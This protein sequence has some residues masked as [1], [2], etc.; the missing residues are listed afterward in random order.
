MLKRV[1]K[2]TI[3]KLFLGLVIL[4]ATSLSFFVSSI[5][6]KSTT[7]LNADEPV[8]QTDTFTFTLSNGTSGIVS[9]ADQETNGVQT[10]NATIDT[11]NKTVTLTRFTGSAAVLTIPAT[12]KYDEGSGDVDYSTIVSST[13]NSYTN[14]VFYNKTS[15]TSVYFENGVV[16]INLCGLFYYCSNVETVVFNNFDTSNCTDMSYMFSNCN[17]LTTVGMTNLDTSNVTNFRSIFWECRAL[18]NVDFSNFNTTKATNMRSMFYYCQSLASIGSDYFDLSLASDFSYFVD[19]CTSLKQIV[20]SKSSIVLNSSINLPTNFS[21]FGSANSDAYNVLSNQN[22]GSYISQDFTGTNTVKKLVC[23]CTIAFQPGAGTLN[24][25]KSATM[26]GY[27]GENI[28]IPNDIYS[29]AGYTL[30]AYNTKSDGTGISYAADGQAQC[31]ITGDMNLYP[32]WTSTS[33]QST[34]DFV[35]TPT[36]GTSGTVANTLNGADGTQTYNAVVSLDA[37]R[38]YLTLY[39]GTATVI[40]VPSKIVYDY[41]TMT[42][43]YQTGIRGG[44]NNHRFVNYSYGAG[45]FY[46]KT[47]LT[48][49]TFEN[50][51]V[52]DTTLAG[53]F[54][55]CTSLTYLDMADFDTSATTNMSGMFM[56]CKSLTTFDI[57]ML[58][59][60]HVTNMGAMFAGCASLTTIDLSNFN[61]SSLTTT[62]IMDYNSG[63]YYC[64]MFQDCSRLESL[65]ISNLDFSHVTSMECMFYNCYSFTSIGTSNDS[66]LKYGNGNTT[67]DTTKVTNMN[68]LFGC[69]NN[70]HTNNVVGGWFYTVNGGSQLQKLDLSHL[71]TDSLVSMKGIF[72][73]ARL[74]QTVGT[75]SNCD[76]VLGDGTTYFNT[77]K[78]TSLSSLFYGFSNLTDVNLSS[79]NTQNVTSISSMFRDCSKLKKVD[80]S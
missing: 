43:D 10:N 53:I 64:G 16:G 54:D 50:G 59:T 73:G 47:S 63:Y 1:S 12:I 4:I 44:T 79:L 61:T 8:A 22:F 39:T 55:N 15:I 35:F 57:T 32:F 65:D 58:D 52:G 62:T 18:K 80:F 17:K 2:A 23:P 25:G 70:S 51:I 46:N 60:S 66:A 36:S 5:Q 75:D 41:G 56:G 21:A 20:L 69:Y 74:I 77:S 19:G 13:S 7:S 78:V 9:N 28:T 37:K 71:R 34:T 11:A 6:S 76:I 45:T 29:R 40:T 24:A 67:I 38:I 48:S 27:Y 30:S 33:G 14:G 42:E 49:I 68:N 26:S 31:M 72:S 3:I